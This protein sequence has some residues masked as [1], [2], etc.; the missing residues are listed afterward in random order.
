MEGRQIQILT[1]V[2]VGLFFSWLS[3]GLRCY[4]RTIISRTFGSDDYWILLGLAGYTAVSVFAYLGVHYGIGVHAAQ[5]TYDQLIN[6]AK[7]Q[8]IVEL[9]YILCTA[10]IKTSVG[11]LLLRITSVKTFYKYLIWISLAIVWIWTIVTFA[12]SCVQCRPLK[13]S[14]D[15]LTPGVCL[16]PRVI[17]NFAYAISA[18][19]IFFD[20]L[21]ALLP[22]PMLWD[23]KMSLRLKCSIMVILSLGI[24]ASASTIIR[25]KYLV[26]F[27]NVTDPLYSITPVFIWSTTEIALGI[28]AASTATLRPLLRSW[29][30][31]GFTSEHSSD[32]EPGGARSGSWN[33]FKRTPPGGSDPTASHQSDELT[34][35]DTIHT[36]SPNLKTITSWSG[37]SGHSEEGILRSPNGRFA[38]N[39][40]G[41][42]G[43]NEEYE[44]VSRPDERIV[45]QTNIQIEYDERM[46]Y[47]GRDMV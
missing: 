1:V 41:R 8:V 15:P 29:K 3:V 17:A 43:E 7:Y 42:E 36:Q 5:L 10:I 38:D 35:E 16:E 12:I 34:L 2:T 23:I 28:I 31:F 37:R 20:W 24:V 32:A 22:I 47:L 44:L 45:R 9:G 40:R 6:A 11:L 18:E 13:A 33:A 4:T 46:N 14:W 25:L 19:T 21:F 27:L 30:I 39:E 26:A